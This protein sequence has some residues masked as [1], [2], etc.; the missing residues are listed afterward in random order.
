MHRE[1][2][3]E[4]L[5]GPAR[6]RLAPQLVERLRVGLLALPPVEASSTEVRRALGAGAEAGE[7]VPERL[8]D[9]LRAHGLYGAN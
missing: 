7:E 6:E 3:P 4:A 8:R 9:Y 2:D 5:L 1:G